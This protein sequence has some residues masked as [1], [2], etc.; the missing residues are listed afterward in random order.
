[1]K[2]KDEAESKK[3]TSNKRQRKSVEPEEPEKSES[4]SEEKQPKKKGRGRPPKEGKNKS[5]SQKSGTDTS[6]KSG[7]AT[8]QRK[9]DIKASVKQ[10]SKLAGKKTPST[11]EATQDDDDESKNA[12]NANGPDQ[13]SAINGHQTANADAGSQDDELFSRF[14]E[15]S[16]LSLDTETFASFDSTKVSRVLK[17]FLSKSQKRVVAK[18]TMEGGNEDDES[19]TRQIPI[20]LLQH[21]RSQVF[22][23]FMKKLIYQAMSPDM[24]QLTREKLMTSQQQPQAQ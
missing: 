24:K 1:M 11:M 16:N 6:Q 10:S 21:C 8:H 15:D 9:R 13:T 17:V 4:D 14:L 22:I 20:Y 7:N 5:Q 18:V 12:T 23:D 3:T 2:E 19:A